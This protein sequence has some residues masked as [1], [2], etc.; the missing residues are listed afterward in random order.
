MGDSTRRHI[1]CPNSICGLSLLVGSQKECV[2]VC[3][4]LHAD[5]HHLR[6]AFLTAWLISMHHHLACMYHFNTLGVKLASKETYKPID[7]PV[8]YNAFGFYSVSC[9]AGSPDDAKHSL[10]SL[11]IWSQRL[12]QT[13]FYSISVTLTILLLQWLIC[14][15]EA[16]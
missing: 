7:I 3:S 8:A 15:N 16:G 5:L 1:E 6:T 9:A 14:G 4:D 12:C 13:A 10:Y 2:C 11:R